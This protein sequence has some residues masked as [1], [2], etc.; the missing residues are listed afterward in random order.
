MTWDAGCGYS[1]GMSQLVEQIQGALATVQR[2]LDA[3]TARGDDQAAFDLARAQYAVSIR[4]SWPSNLAS[5]VS[6]LEQVASNDTLKLSDEERLALREAA[7]VLRGAIN[8]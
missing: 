1:R 7:D 8:Q 6:P 5:L 3:L 4:T 2:I